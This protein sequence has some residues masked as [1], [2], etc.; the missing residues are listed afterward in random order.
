MRVELEL[1][2]RVK[3]AGRK[4]GLGASCPAPSPRAVCMQPV[5]RECVP[6]R[7]GLLRK[8]DLLLLNLINQILPERASCSCWQVSVGEI[9]DVARPSEGER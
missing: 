1:E 4:A 5:L 6:K 7:G 2:Y 3:A 9:S 8:T